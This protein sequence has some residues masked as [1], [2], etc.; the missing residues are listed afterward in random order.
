[1]EGRSLRC[2][3]VGSGRI[4]L[5]SKSVKNSAVCGRPLVS[6]RVMVLKAGIPVVSM[7]VGEGGWFNKARFT[8]LAVLAGV[9]MMF[10]PKAANAGT[11]YVE[12]ATAEEKSTDVTSLVLVGGAVLGGLALKKKLDGRRESRDLEM[13]TKEQQELIQEGRAPSLDL[14]DIERR[15]KAEREMETLDADKDAANDE[16]LMSDLR[17][18]MEKIKGSQDEDDSSDDPN[19]RPGVDGRRD[20]SSRG[21]TGSATLEPPTDNQPRKRRPIRRPKPGSNDPRRPPQSRKA[22]QDQE[23]G[24]TVPRNEQGGDESVSKENLDMLKRM[25]DL[26]GDGEVTK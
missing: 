7:T 1:M 14:R 9:G 23:K 3:F 17:K 22:D 4:V 24:G 10:S 19:N 12:S 13:R 5:P 16:D 25:W 26:S 11:D 20:H 15:E 8:A 21:N 6:S 18:R 2:G